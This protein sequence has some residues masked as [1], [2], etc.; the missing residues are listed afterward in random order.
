[1][2]LV[3]VSDINNIIRDIGGPEAAR[4]FRAMS[5]EERMLVVQCM[6][7]PD[8]YTA[9]LDVDFKEEPVPPTTFFS[10]PYFIGE[11]M[12]WNEREKTGLFPKWREELCYV[13]DPRNG[14]VEWILSGC[15]GAG[16][17]SAALFFA[18]YKL[19]WLNCLRFPTQFIGIGA[20]STAE[21]F[22]LTVN[23]TTASDVLLD[24]FE[25]L[26]G[27][28]P[29]FRDNFPINRRRRNSMKTR[30]K[31]NGIG[32]YK[33]D[34]PPNFSVVEGS[35][36]MHFISRDVIFALMDE[37]NFLEKNKAAMM[38]TNY[39]SESTGYGLYIKL[40]NRILS[41][42]MRRDKILGSICL[43]SSAA[44]D[45]MF[46]EQHKRRARNDPTA[47]ISE[48]ALWEIQP[49]KFDMSETFRVFVGGKGVSS[50][51]LA[52]GEDPPN[53][54]GHVIEVPIS[55]KDAFEKDLSQ[56]LREFAGVATD[57]ANPFI[58]VKEDIYQCVDDSIPRPFS[59]QKDEQGRPT[60]IVAGHL[61]K[62]NEIIDSFDPSKVVAWDGH[63]RVPQYHRRATRFVHVDLAISGCAV[64]ISMGHVA[65]TRTIEVK[66]KDGGVVRIRVPVICMDFVLRL[67]PPPSP[68]HHGYLKIRGF[69]SYLR[70]TLNYYIG[71]VT[72]DGYQSE[73]SVQLLQ[74]QGFNAE[75]LSVDSNPGPYQAFASAISENRVR[76][77]HYQP[78]FDDIES[79]QKLSDGRKVK[80]D[81][82]PGGSKDVSDTVAAVVW[83]GTEHVSS[84]A[85]D[86]YAHEV[87]SDTREIVG[88]RRLARTSRGRVLRIT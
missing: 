47:H 74:R 26:I 63:I 86:E 7:D 82:V 31:S 22:F 78:L 17:T 65:N 84:G 30:G 36:D 43:I 55:L 57:V 45:N 32:D 71:K 39:G 75:K 21:F 54:V 51:I 12:V 19:Y 49:W 2:S 29:Y 23:L 37:A 27:S 3:D 11:G 62:T 33:L 34:F 25:S 81:H 53:D 79:L 28:S 13:L 87:V 61:S 85:W 44:S 18:E 6:N 80:V 4:L 76:Y 16:K 67:L 69:I 73:D 56:A 9:L 66:D 48:F 70:D 20:N 60:G 52:D 64:G 10:D 40:K 5:D 50:R 46:L 24:R 1:M 14:V 42:F 15:L 38:R 77:Y 59:E 8:V 68:E 88:D 41:R 35:G 72:F 83:H 58:S